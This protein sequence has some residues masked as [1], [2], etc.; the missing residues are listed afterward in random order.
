VSHRAGATSRSAGTALFESY[1]AKSVTGRV[2]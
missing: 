1:A 2:N